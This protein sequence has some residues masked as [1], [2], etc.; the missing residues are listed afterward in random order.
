MRNQKASHRLVLSAL[1]AAAALSVFGAAPV[2]AQTT[3]SP[4]GIQLPSLAAQT[5]GTAQGPVRRLSIDEAVALA[6]EQNLDLQVE[7]INP[8]VQDFSISVARSGWVPNF[9][10]TVT[11][12]NQE[13]LPSDI[14]S[15]TQSTITEGRVTT[16]AGVGQNLAWGGA[17]Y[18][19][20][21]VNG[22]IT[23]NNDYSPFNPQLNSRRSTRSRS[24]ATSRST[25]TGSST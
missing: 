8:Q 16:Q 5:T 10:S 19:V 9:F 7:R 15:G 22:R 3:A 17:N 2:R 20:S 6:L 23:S 1:A 25:R 14:F 24:F 13:N 18:Q 21:W 12:R 11:R 4:S